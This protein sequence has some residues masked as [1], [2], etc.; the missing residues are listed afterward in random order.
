MSTRRIVVT[1]GAGFLGS[2]LCERLL[3]HGDEVVCLDN[4][5][6]GTPANVAH[7][8]GRPGFTCTRCDLTEFLHVPG[9]VDLVL[10]FASPASPIDYLRLPIQT[11]K[12]GAIG[13][14]H[15]LGLAKEKRARFLLA[16]TSE[17]YG[18]PK[19]HPQPETYWGHV[20][21]IGP[22]GVYDEAKRYAEALTTA[23]RDSEGLDTAIVRIF[24]TYGPR[25]RPDDG[26]AIPTFIRQALA[27]EPLTVAGDGSQTRSVCHVDDTVTG[28]LALAS[29]EHAGPVNIGNPDE[30]SV[31]AIAR[32]VIAATG[33]QSQVVFIDRPVDDP[34]VRRPD[35]TLACE[36]LGWQPRVSWRDGL[37]A[38]IDWFRTA[39]AQEA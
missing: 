4:F 36:L 27:G 6:T 38:T 37:V 24:N 13:T 22:R 11:L 35:T 30:R 8:L 14:W 39:L 33:N 34:G 15:A 20:N 17:V 2:H 12:V 28:I 5:L 25:M 26:R 16:S 19:V 32:D 31:L 3:A 10:H 1:G 29:S 18:D 23:Y 9:P 21:P 7:L